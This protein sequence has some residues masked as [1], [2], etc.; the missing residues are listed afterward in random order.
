MGSFKWENKM[1]STSS[2]NWP[3]RDRS[4]PPDHGGDSGFLVMP[5]MSSDGSHTKRRNLR[6][7]VAA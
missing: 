4:A 2:I 3:R 6:T 1:E 7:Q 5:A